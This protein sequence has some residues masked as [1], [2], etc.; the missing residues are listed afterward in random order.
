LDIFGVSSLKELFLH[1]KKESLISPSKPPDKDIEH[2]KATPAITIDD[3][4]GQEQAKRALAIAA[5][6]HHNLLL[7][8]SPGTGKTMPKDTTQSSA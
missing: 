1:L 3:V 5:A 4:K 7:S 8:G 2:T 6:G